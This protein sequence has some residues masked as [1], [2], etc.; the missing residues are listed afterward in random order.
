[1]RLPVPDEREHRATEEP[2]VE[3]TVEQD[4]LVVA[5]HERLA[6]REID[7]VLPRQV[8]RTEP[9]YGVGDATRPHLDPD[10]AEHPPEG[11]DVPH[12]CDP[13]QVAAL[14]VRRGTGLVDE[15]RERLVPHGLDV[16][17]V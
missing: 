2:G 4:E 17:A 1:M 13:L 9:T 16:L 7:V 12:D 15:T 11:H 5:R 14:P 10:L 6:E 3:C 8:D